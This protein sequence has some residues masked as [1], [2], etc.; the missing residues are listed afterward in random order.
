MKNAKKLAALVFILALAAAV[1]FPF[2][3]NSERR[4]EGADGAMNYL[5]IHGVEA[6]YQAEKDI[7][8]PEVFSEVYSRYNELQRESG[9]NLLPHRGHAAK[10]Y[11]FSLPNS[12]EAHVI[13]CCGEIVGGDIS[14][15][16]INGEMKG[17][18]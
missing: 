6:V 10:L 7:T 2:L 9:F 8:I 16:A 17:L 5:V 3:R 15:T 13:V 1:V 14:T 12:A 4:A 11:T 18:P